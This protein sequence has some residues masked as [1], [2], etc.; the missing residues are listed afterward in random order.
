MKGVLHMKAKFKLEHE[1]K[2]ALRFQEVDS[3]GKPY[4]S[5]NALGCIVGTL[6]VRKSAFNG[7]TPKQLL[8]EITSVP[9]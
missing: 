2:G 6:Y 8:I 7:E 5:P 9:A 4:E 1:T 3:N